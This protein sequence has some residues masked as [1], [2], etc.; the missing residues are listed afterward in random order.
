MV[1]RKNAIVLDVKE[2][3]SSI[4]RRDRLKLFAGVSD[5]T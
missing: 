3:A 4:I 5:G 2:K 1:Q